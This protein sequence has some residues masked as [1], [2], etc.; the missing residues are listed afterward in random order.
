MRIYK[1]AFRAWVK[2]HREDHFK[3]ADPDYC[4]LACYLTEANGEH[5]HVLDDCAYSS[6]ENEFD[7]PPWAREFV[8]KF[9]ET[10]GSATGAEILALL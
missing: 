7:L 1:N 8:K 3:R 5:F 4:V 2:E 9:D 6:N 10:E